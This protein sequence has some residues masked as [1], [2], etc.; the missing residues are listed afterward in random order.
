MKVKH[1]N[2][3]I[4]DVHMALINVS[5]IGATKLKPEKFVKILFKKSGKKIFEEEETAL[6]NEGTAQELRQ[7]QVLF[8]TKTNDSC[9]W[10]IICLLIITLWSFCELDSLNHT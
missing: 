1:N 3:K 8:H 10:S 7:I 6:S 5:V 2:Y 9:I 4:D